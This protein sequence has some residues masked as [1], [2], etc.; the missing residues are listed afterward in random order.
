MLIYSWMSKSFQANSALSHPVSMSLF[1]LRPLNCSRT[2]FAIFSRNENKMRISIE[3]WIFACRALHSAESP[4]THCYNII[5]FR[6]AAA[7]AHS[8]HSPLRHMSWDQLWL[9]RYPAAHDAERF[10]QIPDAL[11]QEHSSK[12]VWPNGER[13]G[14]SWPS[15][16]HCRLCRCASKRAR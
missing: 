14:D 10:H 9:T 2:I 5:P 13:I 16:L 6:T 7:A 12:N 15:S 11:N 1:S 3:M 8:L 4:Q